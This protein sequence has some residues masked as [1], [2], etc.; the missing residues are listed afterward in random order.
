MANTWFPFTLTSLGSAKNTNNNPVRININNGATYSVTAS[1]A[2]ASVG[3][4][5]VQGFSN[6]PGDGG[7]ATFDGGTSTAALITDVGSAGCSFTDLIFSTSF[8]SGSTDLVTPARQSA[9]M[10]C[11]FTGARGAG[12]NCSTGTSLTECEA[13]SCNKSNTANDG[14]FR[15]NG[16][17]MLRCYAHDNIG[18]TNCGIVVLAGP[19]HVQDCI[20]E[21]N[22]QHGMSLISASSNGLVTVDSC[23]LYNNG[24]DAINIISSSVNPHW[25]ENC[26]FTKNSGA[27]VNN[28][29]VQN[30]GVVYN[31]GY[32]AG[33]QTNGSADTLGP[34]VK[35]G[36]V[37][38][39]TDATPYNA[40]AS[41]D[42]KIVLAAAK[43]AGRGAF[44]QTDGS[45][46]GT[47]GFPDIGSAQHLDSGGTSSQKAYTFG[48]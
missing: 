20:S 13:Y 23:D 45:N 30:S 15:I 3:V 37:A 4:I 1:A 12:I 36:T 18:S 2:F 47:T 48:G 25:I 14:G 21:S 41:G 35:T 24:A 17:N 19:S 28:Q 10:R 43:N 39:A 7:R 32:G 44:T 27:G 5:L 9:W 29:S 42:F 34:L 11:V 40:P 38:Y 16:G 31:C 46:T 8:A 6:S 22:G 33:T 26:N